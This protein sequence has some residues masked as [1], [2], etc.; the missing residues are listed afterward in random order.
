MAGAEA[1]GAGDDPAGPTR[2]ALSV[3]SLTAGTPAAAA[4][5]PDSSWTIRSRGQADGGNAWPQAAAQLRDGEPGQW[6]Q[7]AGVAGHQRRR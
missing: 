7:L 2:T 5:S 6:A 4:S 3:P 1:V